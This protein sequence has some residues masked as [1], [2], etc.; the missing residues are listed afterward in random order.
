M[1]RRRSAT[2]LGLSEVILS[3]GSWR[4]RDEKN[5]GQI[6]TRGSL[7]SG[8]KTVRVRQGP[9]KTY[10]TNTPDAKHLRIVSQLRCRATARGPARPKGRPKHTP[11]L[12]VPPTAEH[13]QLR[14]P[15]NKRTVS[16]LPVA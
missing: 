3:S 5:P 7:R 12:E 11:R 6:R 14:V 9:D 16:W 8:R 15:I 1:E 10:L 4:G 13:Q 2:E